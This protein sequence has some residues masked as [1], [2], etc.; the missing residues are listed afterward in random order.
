MIRKLISFCSAMLLSC[1]V[2]SQNHQYARFANELLEWVQSSTKETLPQ[3]YGLM[4]LDDLYIDSSSINSVYTIKDENI[5]EA[6]KASQNDMKESLRSGFAQVITSMAPSLIFCLDANKEMCYIYKSK[7][8]DKF[9]VTFTVSE[10]YNILGVNS[11]EPEYRESVMINMI[12]STLA[13]VPSDNSS[14]NMRFDKVDH[15]YIAYKMYTDGSWADGYKLNLADNI[16]YDI[17]NNQTGRLFPL[18]SLYLGKGE[19]FTVEDRT[20]SKSSS[21]RLSYDQLLELFNELNKDSSEDVPRSFNVTPCLLEVTNMT[22]MC[23]PSSN[24]QV[25]LKQLSKLSNV[26]NDKNE[27]LSRY[28]P[29]KLNTQYLFTPDGT[30]PS[31]SPKFILD[32]P[33]TFNGKVRRGISLYNDYNVIYYTDRIEEGADF[34][35]FPTVVIITNPDISEVLYAFDFSDFSVARFSKPE[36]AE[37]TQVLVNDVIIEDNVLYANVYH[38]TNASL[39]SGFNAY[40][41]AVDLDTQK[42]KWVTEPLTSKSSFCIDG[43]VIFTGYGFTNEDDYIYIIDKASGSRLKAVKVEKAPE[44]FSVKDGKL[45]VR[46]KGL[47]YVFQIIR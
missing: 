12:Q 18:I 29:E 13:A 4:I 16:S 9:S 6:Y 26:N 36:D 38:K 22:G 17:T 19:S 27:W 47:D 28:L 30:M 1:L 14:F 44:Y 37:Y 35:I 33:Y 21:D 42:I 34:G 46:T 25:S 15:S 31:S 8:G 20:V 40:L 3:D 23:M 41:V 43:D 10:I 24:K 5:F 2:Y 45:H 11:V 32:V 7:G 39:S